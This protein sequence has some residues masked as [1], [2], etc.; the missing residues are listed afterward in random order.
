M[1]LLFISWCIKVHLREACSFVNKLCNHTMLRP[2]SVM[3][4]Y[5]AYELL[6]DTQVYEQL[7]VKATPSQYFMEMLDVRLLPK[8]GSSL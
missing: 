3:A 6:I 4:T 5:F 2:E 7:F 1:P 8:P